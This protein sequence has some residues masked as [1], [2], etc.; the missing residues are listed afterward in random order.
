MRVLVAFASKHGGTQGIAER[1]GE[2]LVAAGQQVD[3]LPAKQVGDLT[4]YGAFVIG[5]AAY[6]GSWLKEATEFVRR[7][8]AILAARPVWLF[9]SGP[10]G[11]SRTDAQGRDLLLTS[12]PK[13]FAEF[14][15][16]IHPRNQQ[17]F[18][19]ALYI[20]KLGFADRLVTKLPAAKAAGLF[21][22]GDFRD[23]KAI[24][25]WAD[26]IARELTPVAASIA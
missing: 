15:E 1:I 25:A 12:E 6:M 9:S 22:E 10:L 8:Q 24:E 2:K 7:S 23:W 16:T 26:S 19:G 3:V 21:P 5:S 18:F 17:V 13:E 4:S 11:T 14:K 20:S